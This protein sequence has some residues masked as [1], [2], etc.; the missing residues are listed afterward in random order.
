MNVLIGSRALAYWDSSFKVRDDAD[1]D[2]ISDEPI[3]G[4]EYHPANFLNNDKFRYRAF[5][6]NLTFNGHRLH[7]LS[8]VHLA[9]IKRSHLWRDLSFDKHITHYHKHLER[10]TA[11]WM[12][13][14]RQLLEERIQLTQRAFPQQQAN[15]KKN[16]QDFFDDAVLKIVD[17]D[18]L[19][20]LVAFYDAPLYKRLQRPDHDIWCHRDLWDAL[21]QSDKIKCVAEEVSVLAI[22]RFLLLGDWN[23]PSK[24]AYLKALR[25]VCTTVTSGYFRDF[26]IDHYPEV[27]SVYN[28][29]VFDKVKQQL[30]KEVK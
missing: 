17:H 21:P 26:A 20:E 2:I 6:S 3:D 1:W 13:Q 28:Q 7:V 9:I 23:M 8:P 19:H 5:E 24:L 18:Y 10:Y 30:V 25:K 16:K 22:E 15:L 29:S 27:I 14:D 11:Q 4:A 12:D